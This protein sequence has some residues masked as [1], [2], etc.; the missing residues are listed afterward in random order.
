MFKVALSNHGPLDPGSI[1][2]RIGLRDTIEALIFNTSDI[3]NVELALW[4]EPHLRMIES[5]RDKIKSPKQSAAVLA[6]VSAGFRSF[7]SNSIGFYLELIR[8]LQARVQLQIVHQHVFP[9]LGLCMEFGSDVVVS[10]DPC[11]RYPSEKLAIS[12]S[13]ATLVIHRCLVRLGDLAR[14]RDL[15]SGHNHK[16][17]KCELA[18]RFYQ[19]ALDLLPDNGHPYNQLSVVASNGETDY[20]GSFELSFR[21]IVIH[22]PYAIAFSNIRAT[23]ESAQAKVLQGV[24]KP[25]SSPPTFAAEFKAHIGLFL[26]TTPSSTNVTDG[27]DLIISKLKTFL[28][29]GA[30]RKRLSISSNDIKSILIVSLGT[31]YLCENPNI[32]GSHVVPALSPKGLSKQAMNEN[33]HA[34]SDILSFIWKLF[35]IV[36]DHATS[37]AVYQL[38]EGIVWNPVDNWTGP[39]SLDYIEPLLLHIKLALVFIVKRSCALESAGLSTTEDWKSVA[40]ICTIVSRTF[41]VLCQSSLE[42]LGAL[43]EHTLKEDLDWRS[44]LVLHDPNSSRIFTLPNTD[45][46]EAKM[47]QI[48]IAHIMALADRLC[49]LQPYKLFSSIQMEGSTSL[50]IYTATPLEADPLLMPTKKLVPEPWD[51]SIDD[52][53]GRNLSLTHSQQLYTCLPHY[54]H[55][56]TDAPNIWERSVNDSLPR[57]GSFIK[58]PLSNIPLGAVGIDMSTPPMPSSLGGAKQTV[59]SDRNSTH[60]ISTL[61][62]RRATLPE[63]SNEPLLRIGRSVSFQDPTSHSENSNDAFREME[64]EVNTLGFL[65]LESLHM[66][67]CNSSSPTVRKVTGDLSHPSLAST[68]I[69][70]P[71]LSEE[72]CH[73][74][75]F[76]R[77]RTVS[78]IVPNTTHIHHDD[79]KNTFQPGV[80]LRKSFSSISNSTANDTT[81]S[82][83]ASQEV[84]LTPYPLLVLAAYTTTRLIND[85][86]ATAAAAGNDTSIAADPHLVSSDLAVFDFGTSTDLLHEGEE[87]I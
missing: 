87:D 84:I 18:K 3:V 8:K 66:G 20:L 63:S 39:E 81:S 15:H 82:I 77:R 73:D 65:D 26:N 32:L 14:Y 71:P 46:S 50:Q 28:S 56:S 58:S 19:T 57:S 22:T 64:R 76:S 34:I 72:S 60:S 36:F 1:T 11:R 30:L 68:G 55:L 9:K 79:S 24:L 85:N 83:W 52:Q 69:F 42:D 2:R 12:D 48:R 27:S 44:F 25:N 40:D 54:P 7:L 10:G 61:W 6:L 35:V 51:F 5:Y 33:P 4:K 43:A 49:T 23:C 70:Y 38:K 74:R 47:T 21:S 80:S 31:L 37:R 75:Q 59:L 29:D 86:V 41:S 78:S 62:S 17:L 53:S 45:F 13:H 16:P 67:E